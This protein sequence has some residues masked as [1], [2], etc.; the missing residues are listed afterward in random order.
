M[1]IVLKVLVLYSFHNRKSYQNSSVNI[2]WLKTV[3]TFENNL[4]HVS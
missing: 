2:K 1:N 3:E 4:R